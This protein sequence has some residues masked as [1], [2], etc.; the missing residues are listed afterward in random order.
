MDLKLKTRSGRK[1]GPRNVIT[2]ICSLHPSEM[3]SIF[4]YQS[5]DDHNYYLKISAPRFTR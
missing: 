5:I 3:L 4:S 1:A 2:E